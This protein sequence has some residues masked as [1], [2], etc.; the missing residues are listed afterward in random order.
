MGTP[1]LRLADVLSRFDQH[2]D[3]AVGGTAGAL[4][5]TAGAMQAVDQGLD[6]AIQ[7]VASAVVGLGA[8]AR[9]LQTGKVSDYYA[10]AAVVT[11]AA[12]LLLIVVR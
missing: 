6:R 8:L 2:L 9:R 7:H 12:V 10:A 4:T 5:R 11:V 3:S 1:T